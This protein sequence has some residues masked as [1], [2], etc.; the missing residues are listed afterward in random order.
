MSRKIENM[1]AAREE[2]PVQVGEWAG[3]TSAKFTTNKAHVPGPVIDQNAPHPMYSSSGGR[4][5]FEA[6]NDQ[7]KAWRSSVRNGIEPA[8][9]PE[10]VSGVKHINFKPIPTKGNPERAHLQPKYPSLYGPTHEVHDQPGLKSYEHANQK[11]KTE[12]S[13]ESVMT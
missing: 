8:H 12:Y 1:V 4:M 9:K 7:Q 2:Q 10:P 11:S 3:H 13:Q 5:H 6:K